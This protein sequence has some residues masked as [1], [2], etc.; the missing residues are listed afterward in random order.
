MSNAVAYS[1]NDVV[2]LAWQYGQ[3]LN[4]CLG[5]RI[6]RT[7]TQTHMTKALPAWVGFTGTTNPQWQPQTT[8]EWPVQKFSWRDLTA[9]RGRTYTYTIT[10][11]TGAP[12]ALLPLTAL[13]LVTPAVTL[14]PKRGNF[15]AYFNRGILS[16]QFLAHALPSGPTGAPDFQVLTNRIDQPG[17]P[18]RNKLAGEMITALR[19]LID[20]AAAQGGRCYLALYELNDTELLQVLL[21]SAGLI[22]IILSNTGPDD[23]ENKPARQSLHEAGIAI[24]DRMVG[25]GHIGHNKFCLYVDGSNQ[26]KA[27]LTGST[28][29]TSTGLCA[30]SNNA[31]IIESDDVAQDYFDYWHR[32]KTDNSEQGATLR[33]SNRKTF[34]AV[35]G[36]N[37]VTLYFSPNTVLKNKPAVNP[38]APIDMADVFARINAATEGILFL[39]FQPGSPSILDA[40]GAAQTANPQLFVRGAATDPQ[41]VADFQSTYLFHQHG[42]DP[43]EVVAASAINDQFGSFQKELLKSSPGAH[44]IIHDKIVVIDPFSNNPTVITG[45]HNDGYRASYNNDENLVIVTGNQALAQAYATHVFDVYDHYRWRYTLGK[46]GAAAWTGLQKD[47]KWQ[48]K[49]FTPAYQPEFKFM[50]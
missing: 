38:P 42:I 20:R 41:A 22:E 30:Q 19:S 10:P 1:N 45:S 29:W 23:G 12:G 9:A 14:T 7:D 3:R 11:M 21:A 32:L 24:T 39:L 6:E 5:F 44:A 4:G 18:L 49:Y 2:Q 37:P 15:S 25:S 13:K 35:V 17:D 26:P 48:D 40:V 34:P 27:V 28:N 46:N 8:N 50:L 16:T 36:G 47:D 33:T 31:L 43:D